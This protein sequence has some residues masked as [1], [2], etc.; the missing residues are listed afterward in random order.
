[1]EFPGCRN[2]SKPT[3]VSKSLDEFTPWINLASMER[4]PELVRSILLFLCSVQRSPP[5]SIFIGLGDLAARLD[6]AADRVSEELA[7]LAEKDFI[8]GPGPY[9]ADQY[10]FRKLTAKGRTFIALLSN[11]GDWRRAKAL[12][13]PDD[14]P[15]T[16]G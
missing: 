5:E 11:A 3:A 16:R 6:V 14:A 2:R 13:L 4:D 1:M 8:E 12:Y 7:L 15:S 10:L 9:G